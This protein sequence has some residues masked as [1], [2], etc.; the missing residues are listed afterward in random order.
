MLI[1]TI[2]R[3]IYFHG[4][5]SSGASST[6]KNL[7]RLLPEFAVIA[8]DIPVDPAKALVELRELC[9]EMSPDLVV[10]TSMGG[11]YAQQMHGQPKLLINP[12]F[13]VSHTLR[14]LEGTDF[15]FFN[16]R[17]DG[18]V[19]FRVTDRLVRQYEDMERHQFDGIIPFDEANTMAL[20]G[21]R[22]DVVDCRDEYL[23]H[24]AVAESFDCGHRVEPK[25]LE[26]VIVPLIRRLTR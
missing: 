10:G 23:A 3:L 22:D 4:L 12:A 19:S 2:M 1:H 26:E 7:R 25:A 20:F 21:T 15:T 18:A 13:H 11:M 6:V 5:G 14:K 9:I 8:P 16:R 24:Y 17:S